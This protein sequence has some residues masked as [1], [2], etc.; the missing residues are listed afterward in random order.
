LPNRALFQDRVGQAL[1]AAR[2]DGSEVAVMLVDLD[3]FKEVNDTLGHQYGDH[4]LWQVAERFTKTLREQDTVARLGG[5]EFAVLLPGTGGTDA[6]TAAQRLTASL[7]ETFV[8][9]EISVDVEASIGIAF[10]DPGS[11]VD[12][13]LRHADIAMYEAKSQHIAFATYEQG[14][15]DN[16][17]ARLGLLGELRRAIQAGELT[18][19]Y[20]PK[21]NTVTNELHSVEALVRWQ[22][23][24]RGLLPPGDFI[25]I[26]EN[27]AVIHALTAEVL[28]VALLQARAWFDAGHPIPVAVN[29]S[30]RSLHDPAFPQHVARQLDASG[31]PPELLQLEL[32]ES[33]IMIDP[34]GAL[35]TLEALHRMGIMLS[36]DDFG[37]GYSS[38]AY[39]KALPVR[40][41]KID[42]SFVT[43]MTFDPSDAMLVQSAIDLAHN[44]G[45]HVVAEG[46]EDHAAQQLLAQMGCDLAQGYHIHKPMQ[47]QDL[48]PWLQDHLGPSHLATTRRLEDIASPM[49]SAPTE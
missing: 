23:P 33:A 21:V 27:T 11:D 30:A 44:L 7:D 1:T 3:R 31:L 45:L 35:H 16:T 40:E 10:A 15:D 5:D 24:T 42:R 25:P 6:A 28:R 22:H 13:L 43:G 14:R 2:R 41:L 19:H 26:A 47:A 9:R 34:D 36:I 17:V 49:P 37:T 48:E 39:L 29:L 32:T 8:I 18:L 38:M 12:S 20:Q 4:L 46:V